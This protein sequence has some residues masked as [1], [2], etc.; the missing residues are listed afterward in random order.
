MEQQNMRFIFICPWLITGGL[1]RHIE[2]FGRVGKG[3]RCF[4]ASWSK[5]CN[6]G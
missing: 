1:Y 4:D 2:L 3:K 5:Q 6:V